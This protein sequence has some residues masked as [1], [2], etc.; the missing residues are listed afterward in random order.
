MPVTYDNIATTTLGTAASSITFSSIS[1][2]Y[3]DLKIVCFVKSG[4]N[5]VGIRYNGDTASNYSTTLLRGNGSSAASTRKTSYSFIVGSG[6]DYGFSSD[7]GMCIID[8]FSYAGSTYKTNLSSSAQDANGAG[9]STV[10]A[11][12]WR[13]TSAITS[14]T[15]G[16]TYISTWTNGTF[17]AGSSFTLYGILKA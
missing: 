5:E 14:I 12:L 16:S 8:I 10:L 13:S 6:D 15:L 17:S 3:T 9:D 7:G 1:S 11:G 4:N 2:A